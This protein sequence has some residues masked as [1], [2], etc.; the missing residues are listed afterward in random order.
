MSKRILIVGA[1]GWGT[2]MGV[3][4]TASGALVT[5]LAHKPERAEELRRTRENGRLLKGVKLPEN[6]EPVSTVKDFGAFSWCFCAVPTRFVRPMFSPLA[7]QYPRKLPLISLT[8]GIEQESLLFPSALLKQLVGADHVLALSGPSHAEEVARGMPA[9]VVIAGEAQH[10]EAAQKLVSG[11]TFRAYVTDDL[12]GVELAGAAKNVVAIAAGIL[13]GL[14]FGDNAKAALVAR[15]LAEIT[16]LG[17]ALGAHERTFFGLSGVGDLYTTCA[18]PH[19]RNRAFGLRI[20]RGEKPAAIIASQEMEVE[21]YNTAK[22][23]KALAARAGVEMPIVDQA[24]RVLYEGA[25]PREAVI[26]LMTR[27]LKAE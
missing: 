15:G 26:E 16:R 19:G 22:A 20:G 17:V 2:A 13:E 9:S 10:A 4:L 11:K 27:N 5:L 14:K 1:G 8:K 12:L 21:G 7:K 25:D 3:L 6:I 24:C 18:S 23:L